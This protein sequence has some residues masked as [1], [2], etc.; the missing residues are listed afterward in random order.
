M[1]D[2]AELRKMLENLLLEREARFGFNAAEPSCSNEAAH[3]WIAGCNHVLDLLSDMLYGT[4]K[5]S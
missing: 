5:E 4:T 3:A 1:D 2:N